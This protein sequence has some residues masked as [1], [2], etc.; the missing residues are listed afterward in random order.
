MTEEFKTSKESKVKR[1]KVRN[2]LEKT[3]RMVFL[4]RKQH[5][6]RAY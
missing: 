1:R 3:L 6:P 4:F 5:N 2:E